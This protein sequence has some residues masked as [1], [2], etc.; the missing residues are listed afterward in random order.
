MKMSCGTMLH[1]HGI[2]KH[3][4]FAFAHSF[5]TSKFI[6]PHQR[7]GY[8]DSPFA[9]KDTFPYCRVYFSILQGLEMS[10]RGLAA[11]WRWHKKEVV[12]K[13]KQLFCYRKIYWG[14]Q[15]GG[16]R[17]PGSAGSDNEAHLSC[18][19]RV[20]ANFVQ[21]ESI[22]VQNH[23]NQGFNFLDSGNPK[24]SRR[25]PMPGFSPPGFKQYLAALAAKYSKKIG[26]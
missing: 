7:C 1:S 19:R 11:G 14:R 9:R 4:C 20:T 5:G 22:W 10:W 18:K 24:F 8:S 21:I 16:K 12:P 26:F 25:R 2:A 6:H 3:T 17:R 15:T 23:K 13:K